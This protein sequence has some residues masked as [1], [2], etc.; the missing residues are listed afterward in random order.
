L[1]DIDLQKS[2]WIY[3]QNIGWIVTGTIFELN[4]YM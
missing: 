4:F 3:S 1:Y 2:Y